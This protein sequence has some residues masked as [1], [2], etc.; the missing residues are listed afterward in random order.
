[1]TESRDGKAALR[2]RRASGADT[3]AVLKLF[4]D[5][6]AWF[7]AIGNTGQWGTRPWSVQPERR[8]HV[9]ELC[10][11]RG[12]WIAEAEDGTVLG[13]VVVGVAR[14]YVPPAEDENELY[15]RLLIGS[16]EP[17]ARGVGRRLLAFADER[18]RLAGRRTLRVDCYAGGTGRLVEFYESCG[19]QR[20][21]TFEVR[22]WPGQILVRE[23]D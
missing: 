8:T 14:D 23:L 1:M 11:E 12:A 5:A 3:D 15:I 21:E 16:R 22:D 19:Y 6:I 17:R 10:A 13:I 9:A 7:V 2:I 18:A 20:A 4:D